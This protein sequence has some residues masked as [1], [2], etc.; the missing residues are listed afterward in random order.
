MKRILVVEDD[1]AIVRGLEAALR[2]EHFDVLSA[3]DGEKGLL[4][5]KRENIDLILLDIMLPG[6]NGTEV[7]RRLR[8]DGVGTPIMMLTSKDEEMDKVLGLELGADDYVT[9]PFSIRELL[10][11]I[12][13]LLRRHGTLKTSIETYAFGNVEIDFPKQEAKAGGAALKLTA[14]EF[15]VLKYFVEHEGEV[16]SRE[17]FLNEVWGYE[18]YPTTRTVDNYILSL[19]KKVEPDPSHPK[20]LLT[21]HTVGY[22]FVRQ[23]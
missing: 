9:K 11:R 17:Q 18:S 7:C 14:T 22:K 15:H 8:D 12:K 10:A 2:A 3:A 1:P 6:I 19:R 23:P 21:V 5:A 13:A 4:M 16:V 20:H